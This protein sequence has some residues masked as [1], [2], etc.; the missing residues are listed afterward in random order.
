MNL[1]EINWWVK[2]PIDFEHK[3]WLFLAYL[4]DLDE[5]L[6]KREFSPW[7]LHS[8]KL[9]DDMIMSKEKIISSKE[10]YSKPKFV[11]E[12]GLIKYD[13]GEPKTMNELYVY[14]EILDY[15]TP[16]LKDKVLFGRDL[17]GSNK[18]ILY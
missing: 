3:K 17:W 1:L 14:L 6:Y 12:E 10:L 9:L 18:K 15:S 5:A 13:P 16:L 2:S 7:L 4:R 11:F 8:E